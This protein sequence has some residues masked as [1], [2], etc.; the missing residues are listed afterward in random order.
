MS[1][2]LA[3]ELSIDALDDVTDGSHGFEVARLHLLAGQLLELNDEVDGVDAVEVEIL[4]ESRLERDLRERH[5]EELVQ[6]ARERCQNLAARRA[7]PRPFW[8]ATKR[9]ML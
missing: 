2:G 4:E 6:I 5:L 1:R 3:L 7:H 9:A 8:L